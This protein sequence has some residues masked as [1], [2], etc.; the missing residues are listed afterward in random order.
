MAKRMMP[1]GIVLATT[2]ALPTSPL[3]AGDFAS[4]NVL[5]FSADGGIFVF[6]EFGVQDGSGFPYANRFYIDTST[7]QFISG[8]PIRVRIDDETADLTQARSDA[9]AQGQSIITDAVLAENPGYLAGFNTVT[10][11]SA[12]PFRMAVNPR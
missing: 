12:D 10:E 4:L 1:F 9:A 6:E 3:Y 2:L 5:G 7:D 11:A 8:T